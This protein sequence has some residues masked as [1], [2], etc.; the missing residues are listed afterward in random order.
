[1]P[2]C[3]RESLVH[4]LPLLPCKPSYRILEPRYF[5]Y[6]RWGHRLVCSPNNTSITGDTSDQR[7]V[8]RLAP[9]TPAALTFQNVLTKGITRFRLFDTLLT[10][11]GSVEGAWVEGW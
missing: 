8:L 2:V 11:R 7:V 3:S 6:A 9:A 4:S 1:M 10:A 5:V